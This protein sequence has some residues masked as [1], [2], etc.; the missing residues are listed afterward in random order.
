VKEIGAFLAGVL[1]Q[2]QN[3]FWRDKT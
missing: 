2:Q 3:R 1:T